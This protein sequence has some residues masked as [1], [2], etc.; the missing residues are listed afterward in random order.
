M[1]SKKL[2]M[3]ILCQAV[4][5]LYFTPIET[6]SSEKD[7]AIL[8][9][10][11]GYT[12]LIDTP[13]QEYVS[14]ALRIAEE[15]G[16][17]LIIQLD[18]YGGYL[19]PALNIATILLNA[20]V[21]TIVFVNNRAYSAGAVIAIAAH[22]LAMRNT[23]IIGAAQPITINPMTGEIIFLNESKILNPLLKTL[24]ICAETRGRNTSIVRRFVYENL[25]LTGHEAKRLNI[26][27]FV[28]DTIDDLLVELRG[29]ELNI[30]GSTWKLWLSSYEKLEP[31]LDI[32]AKIFLR[33]SVINSIL[34]FIGMFG[35]LALLVSGRMDLLPIT[36]V[37]LLLALIG[38]DIEARAISLVL[39][40]LGSVLLFIELFI[41]PGFGILGITG[42]IATIAGIILSPI[43][44]SMYTVNVSALWSTAVIVASSFGALFLFILYKTITTMKRPKA[45]IYAPEGKYI[46]KAIDK[47]EPGKKGYIMING[48]L[49]IAESN[50][51]IEPG[52]EVEVIERK[53]LTVKVKRK[54]KE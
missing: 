30:S 7:R 44:T 43:P 11:E 23:A 46:G 15:R 16:V 54:E 10:I 20:K 25:V 45:V 37:A 34:F 8:I 2:I 33:N 51:I 5:L 9:K 40:T 3:L 49:W 36:I 27:D 17:P 14:R 6:L 26:A 35:T 41:T 4:L 22:I 21:P 28:V 42:I 19:D 24:E 1:R 48:E 12:S 47:I 29:I 32:Y 13:V 31:E 53:G 52:T 50:D 38:G 18:T 39:I